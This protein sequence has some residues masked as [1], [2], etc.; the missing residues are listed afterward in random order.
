VGE[1]FS[2][3][4]FTSNRQDAPVISHDSAGD[5][6]VAWESNTQD[7]SLYGVFG[8]FFVGRR[9]VTGPAAAGASRVRVF[10]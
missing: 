9:L 4:S 3:N 7:G 6:V 2:V 1:E 10:R 8:E 5:F